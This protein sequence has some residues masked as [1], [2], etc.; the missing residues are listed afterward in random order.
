MNLD[1]MSQGDV[2][3]I[4]RW[5]LHLL[6]LAN[7][8]ERRI[9]MEEL[10]R[11]YRERAAATIAPDAMMRWADAMVFLIERRVKEI[12]ASGGGQSGSA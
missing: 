8:H 12:Q 2:D 4:H 11:M 6:G 1:D 7:D 5:T 10:R 9:G 3:E